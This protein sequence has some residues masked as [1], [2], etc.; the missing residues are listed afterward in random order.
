MGCCFTVRYRST[1]VFDPYRFFD[2]DVFADGPKE[3]VI[4]ARDYLG[5][6]KYQI[7]EVISD[8]EV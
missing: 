5:D 4:M 1:N 2:L 6:S 8:V 3:A 7:V